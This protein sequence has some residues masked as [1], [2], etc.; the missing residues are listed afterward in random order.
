MSQ[1]SSLSPEAESTQRVCE[2]WYIW[3]HHSASLWSW[4][5]LNALLSSC[6]KSPPCITRTSSTIIWMSIKLP[7]L[8]LTITLHELIQPTHH[9]PQI[10]ELFQHTLFYWTS[11]QMV[12]HPT[13][14]C[15]PLW[16]PGFVSGAE[17]LVAYEQTISLCNYNKIIIKQQT[18]HGPGLWIWLNPCS[19]LSC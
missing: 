1:L 16:R 12:T 6:P 14:S 10:G 8:L 7:N 11:L 18:S 13:M 9:H 3:G 15:A 19:K 2:L 4:L 5:H 17:S